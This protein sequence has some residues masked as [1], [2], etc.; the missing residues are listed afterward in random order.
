MTFLPS[1]LKVNGMTNNTDII[2]TPRKVSV[3]KVGDDWVVSDKATGEQLAT[4]PTR[5][6]ARE[7]AATLR[8]GDPVAP[9]PVAADLTG[10][11]RDTLVAKA[12]E[13]WKAAK[14]ARAKGRTEPATPHLDELNRRYQNGERASHDGSS[15]GNGS[16]KGKVA[17][18][19]PTL[20]DGLF[21]IALRTTKVS[22]VVDLVLGTR[23]DRDLAEGFAVYHAE[24]AQELVDILVEWA[25]SNRD[26]VYD[27]RIAQAIAVEIMHAN[28]MT[29]SPSQRAATVK[30]PAL[31]NEQSYEWT[32]TVNQDGTCAFETEIGGKVVKGTARAVLAAVPT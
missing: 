23:V 32:F 31:L 18:V 24:E 13:E 25:S 29:V 2:T 17:A 10:V 22:A 8:D 12:N 4:A 3:D 7:L 11:D 30:L 1:A 5:T 6:A 9:E 20:D 14:A 16:S 21:S 26:K 19:R 28:P 27:A 15:N